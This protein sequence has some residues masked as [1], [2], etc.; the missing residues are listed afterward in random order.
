VLGC[1]VNLKETDSFD[2]S[3]KF[4]KEKK[5][6]RKP[7]APRFNK[8]DEPNN[9]LKGFRVYLHTLPEHEKFPDLP[10]FEDVQAIHKG[11]AI[12][13][14]LNKHGINEF[15]KEWKKTDVD[16]LDEILA[17]EEPA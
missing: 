13:A 1:W 8:N 2:E 5:A 14:A 4:L 17:K 7:R 9:E 12:I 16:Y 15:P 3:K 6:D 11:R 10:V